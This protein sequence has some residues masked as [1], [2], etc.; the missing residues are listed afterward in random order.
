MKN[1]LLSA[2]M[3]F[4]VLSTSIIAPMNVCAVSSDTTSLSA[5]SENESN[6]TTYPVATTNVTTTTVA[7]TSEQEGN[8]NLY[9]FSVATSELSLSVGDTYQLNVTF[10]GNNYYENSVVFSSSN[11]GIVGVTSEGIV[12]AREEG[13]TTLK[14]SAKVN[15]E[16]IKLDENESIVKT[17]YVKVNVSPDKSL[18][19]EQNELLSQLKEKGNRLI[20]EFQRKEKEIRGEVAENSPRV[21]MNDIESI[22]S[23]SGTYQE[24]VNKLQ[25]IQKYPDFIGGSGVTKIEY[26]FDDNGYQKLLL[27]HEEGDV[28]Y[29]Q[30]N[31]SGKIT[32]WNLLCPVNKDI[33]FEAYQTKMIGSFNV[34]ND[35]NVSDT[36]TSEEVYTGTQTTAIVQTTT[37]TSTTS[38]SADEKQELLDKLAEKENLLFGEFQR[39]RAV[40]SGEFDPNTAR[41]TLDVVNEIINNAE[42][43]DEMYEKVVALQKYPDFIGGSGVTKVEYWLD[44]KGSE[45]IRFIVE[46]HDIVYVKCNDKGCITDWQALYRENSDVNLEQYKSQMIDSYMIYND[47]DASGDINCDGDLRISDIVMFQKWLLGTP[48]AELVNWK[49]GDF[50]KDNKL[51]VFDLTL[52]R[53]ELIYN[54]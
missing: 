9:G 43:F 13:S 44:D 48:D 3:A 18:T 20:G 51:N 11:S 28:I 53:K 50:C 12:T 24:I 1:K 25:M 39:E 22:I 32:D 45:K 21:T 5:A 10:K 7:D 17:L 37:T 26:W 54:Q 34:Y 49:A 41:L 27:I 15:D 47:I 31:D 8:D 46:E 52:M 4:G 36:N 30:C 40:I 14:I 35:I 33:P 23:E 42:N 19:A 29:V 6:T 16:K 2:I 38:Q